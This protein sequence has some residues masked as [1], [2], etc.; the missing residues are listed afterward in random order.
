M[1]MPPEVPT[2]SA[3]RCSALTRFAGWVFAGLAAAALCS[4]APGPASQK[5]AAGTTAAHSAP[6]GLESANPKTRAKAASQIGKSGDVAGIPAL[7]AA[8]HDPSASVRRQVVLALA[9]FT[10]PASLNGLIEATRDSDPSVRALAVEA[11]TG[12]YTGHSPSTGFVGFVEK[13]YKSIK[14]GFA[15]EDTEVDPG[16]VVDPRAV[17]ALDAAMMDTRFEAAARAAARGLGI[18]DARTAV[19]DLVVTAHSP[20]H[21]LAREALNSLAKI[22]DT[23]AGP[24]LVDL[25]KS[26]S[27][28]LQQDAAVTV[29]I[30]RTR[31][32]VPQLQLLA[33]DDPNSTTRLKALEGLAYVGDPVSAPIFQ[34]NLWSRNKAIR[35]YAAEGLGR[36][37]Y[38][39]SLPDLQKAAVVEKD[40]TARLAMEFA[41]TALG[42]DEYLSQMVADLGSRLRAD[43][44]QAYLT[45]LA[46]NPS[47]LPKLYPFLSSPNPAVRSRLCLVLMYSGSSSSVPLLLKATHDSNADVAT[48]A[49][50]A[51]R[52]IRARGQ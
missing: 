1:M 41:L 14:R 33:Q 37:A 34:K 11:V 13:E 24:R 6:T 2:K 12:Y 43:T 20:D 4:A 21:N 47:F 35:T 5:P 7:V 3:K 27:P 51:L 26:S 19:P 52:A 38:S 42:N 50:R 8:L 30:L 18:L 31:Q 15:P 16:T 36:S 46:Q 39:P 17:A 9:S 32:A 22:K 40:A 28:T 45:E 29:G 48:S 49:M 10:T 44:A 23:S 25:L